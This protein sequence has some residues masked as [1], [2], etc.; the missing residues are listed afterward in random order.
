MVK[1]LLNELSKVSNAC[2]HIATVNE[3]ERVKSES[4][5]LFRIVNLELTI[6]GD[7]EEQLENHII[8]PFIS[9]HCGWTGAR[10]MPITY[11]YQISLNH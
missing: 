5:V 6:M 3:V 1:A 8:S 4:P 10:S 11:R 2:V 7:P 9:Y